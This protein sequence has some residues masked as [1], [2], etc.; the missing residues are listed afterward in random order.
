M[1]WFDYFNAIYPEQETAFDREYVDLGRHILGP[2]VVD[3]D[4]TVSTLREQVKAGRKYNIL[5]R[6]FGDGILLALPSSIGRST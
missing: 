5:S 3:S 6:K 4:A 1:F 2:A